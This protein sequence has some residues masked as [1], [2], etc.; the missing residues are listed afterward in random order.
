M[1]G[2]LLRKTNQC[3]S[4]NSLYFILVPLL[5]Q[6]H[7]FDHFFRRCGKAIDLQGELHCI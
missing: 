6:A 7:N 3:Q 1:T 5:G 2:T 4:H